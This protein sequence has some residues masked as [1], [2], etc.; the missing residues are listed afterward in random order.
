MVKVTSTAKE[1]GSYHH[2]DLRRALIDNGL[3][4]LEENMEANLGLRQL[5]RLAGVSPGAVYRHF[6]NKEEL[7]VALAVE[8]FGRLTQKQ[9]RAY[10]E[11]KT[12]SNAM[13]AFRAGGAAYIQ[14][15]RE[16]P[17][18][19]RLMFGRFSATHRNEELA[20][21]SKLNR[22]MMMLSISKVLGGERP[23][24]ELHAFCVGTWAMIHGLSALILD[25]Q[26]QEEGDDLD[27][28]VEDIIRGASEWE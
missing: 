18:L 5:A 14:F 1:N 17:A 28:L 19:F 27:G 4:L 24:R 7:L 6:V 16:N 20:K 26:L 12:V 11:K 23:A 22:D 15:A 2:G 10:L 3:Q 25:Q 21:A 9:S 8:G 13:D